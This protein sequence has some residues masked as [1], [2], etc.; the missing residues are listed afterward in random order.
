MGER[1]S[2]EKKRHHYVPITYLNKF[3]D[4][5][6]NVFAYRKDSPQP[7][8]YTSPNGIG[9]ETYYYSQP[10][11]DGGR[12][13]NTFEDFFGTIESKWTPLAERLRSGSDAT[14]NFTSSDFEALFVFLVLM[15]VRVPATRDMV[16][17]SL[18]E[19]VKA[20]ARLLDRLGKLPPKPE[21]MEDILDHMVAAIDPHQ[22]LRAM[23][24]LAKG[25]GVVLDHV[26]FE[27]VH[28]GT[29]ISFLTSDNPVVCFD[30]TVQEA[31]VLPYQVR[32]PR[33]AIELLFPIDA[34]T[35]LR[36][37][38]GLRR[39]PDLRHVT[40]TDRQEAKR[41]NRFVAASDIALSSRATEPMK[42]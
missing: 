3:T 35:L 13:N 38:S 41:I 15:R 10:L 1:P 37:R 39:P 14:N 17:I 21:G 32:P 20:E 26:G 9:F 24:E 4:A 30:P 19:Q 22:S 11:P 33:G 40:L 2:N 6:G 16:E 28:N 7:P 27:V 25:F 18:S 42:P 31:R 23:G 36:G 34:D 8:L 5:S 12:D 29:E